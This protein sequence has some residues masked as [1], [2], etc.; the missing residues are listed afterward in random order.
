MV[1]TE[2][3]TLNVA[4]LQRTCVQDGPGL[5]TTIFFR[6]C[7]LRCLWCQNPE[8]LAPAPAAPMEIDRIL[9]TVLRDRAYYDAAGGGV[10]LSGGEPFLQA[11]DSLLAL[12]AALKSEGIHLSAETSLHAP[13][14]ALEAAARYID[15]FLV[16]FKAASDSLHK[17]LTGRG[18]ALILDNLRRLTEL[19]A[20]LA[21]RMVAVPGHNDKESE[22][23]ALSALLKSHGLFE[24]ELL[25]YHSMYEDKAEK[26]GLDVPRLNIGGGESREALARVMAYFE[27]QG[28]RAFNTELSTPRDE[29]VFTERVLSIQQDIRAAGRALCMETALLKTAYYKKHKGWKK[30]APIHRSERLKYVLQNKSIQVYP[31]ELLV[32]NFTAKR[33]AGQVWEEQYGALYISFLYQINRQKPVKFQCSARE[34]MQFYFQVFPHWVRHSLIV[35]AHSSL[36]EFIAQVARLADMKAGFNN[37][38]AAIAHFVVNFERFLENGT[39]GLIEEIHEKQKER[40]HCAEYQGMLLALEALEAFGGRYAALL[41][42][43]AAGETEPARKKEL[44]AMAETCRRV[45]KY[46]ARTYREALQSM[47]FLQIAL[48]IEQYENAISY[49]RMDQILYPYYKRDAE[50]GLISYEE[51]KELLCLFILKMDEVILVNDGAGFLS[52][53]QNFETLSTDQSL[54]F[55]GVDR[56]GADATNDITYMLIDACELQP[57]SVN[58]VARVHE[59]SPERYMERLAEIYRNGCPMPELFADNI[60]LETLRRHYPGITE[61][62]ARNY[63]IVGCVEPNC[64]DDHFGNTDSA[65]INIALPFLQA[66]KGQD[67]DLWNYGFREQ[68]EQLYTKFVERVHLNR[69]H[70]PEA[71]ARRERI[72]KQ[73]DI[74]RGRYDYRP[75]QSMEELLSRYQRRLNA[76]AKSVLDDQQRIERTLQRYFPAPLCSSLYK[77][78]V[79]RGMDAYEGGTDYNTAGIQAVGVTDVADSLYAIDELVFRR[80]RYRM[81]EIL[82]AI[83]ANFAGERNQRIRAELRA[84]PKFGEDG[85]NETV[86]WVNKVMEIYNKALATCPYATRNGNYTAGYYA[87]NVSDRYGRRTQALPSGRLKG[88]PLANS[89]TPHYGMEQGDLLSALNSMARVNFSDYAVNGSTATLT[90]DAALFPGKSGIKNLA[91]I[92]KTYLT[93]GGIQ[94]QP[95]IVS[96]E[97]LLDA[98]EHPEKHKYLMV[99]VAGYCAYFQELSD[100]LKRVIINRTCY[101]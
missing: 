37:N 90:V 4:K 51:A 71:I 82:E 50:A 15:L 54:T 11:Q 88:V 56:D 97:L 74:K 27:E 91:A 65:N 70:G 40:P 77:G 42:S 96:R 53:S 46:P 32:G 47:L 73:R 39:S 78:C 23:K 67:Y 2:A 30:P 3:R 26:L 43:E 84:V 75:P 17:K 29:A 6:G 101:A 41:A 48:C 62:D 35:K 98:Y 10:T 69:A 58:M 31:G 60:Y 76:L 63:S 94:L 1:T 79:A 100:E 89:V 95:N 13:W 19:G 87:L 80:G 21:P 64:S 72:I 92:F 8:N 25:K 55:G 52:L 45:P 20:K 83:D 61:R 57:L 66:L 14:S 7:G 86:F 24:I 28:I 22:I 93:R 99:R 36:K 5:R 81:E 38:F 85:D 16:D 12:L 44:A 49:G 68:A 18:N 33:V 34:R 9:E 59:N